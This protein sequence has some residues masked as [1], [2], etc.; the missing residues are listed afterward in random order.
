MNIST[1]LFDCAVKQAEQNVINEKMAEFLAR[2]GQIRTATN[3]GVHS[4]FCQENKSVL[5]DKAQ[6]VIDSIKAGR[7]TPTKIA[8]A[9]NFST[10][11]VQAILSFLLK[12][13]LIKKVG[14]GVRVVA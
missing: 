13:K 12:Q 2:G 1:N 9:V 14:R 6:K 4:N 8:Q 3:M 10:F 11:D 7:T 5:G